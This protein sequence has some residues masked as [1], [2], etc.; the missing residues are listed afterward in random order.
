MKTRI[1]LCAVVLALS[2]CASTGFGRKAPASVAA[3]G[4]S[5]AFVWSV[6]TAP[7]GWDEDSNPLDHISPTKKELDRS[8]PLYW[9]KVF[10]PSFH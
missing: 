3:K 9:Q 10:D 8:S 1:I 4:P 6:L 2:S 5:H 7:E